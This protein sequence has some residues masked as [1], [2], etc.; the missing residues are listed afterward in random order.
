MLSDIVCFHVGHYGHCHYTLVIDSHTPA[1]CCR[2]LFFIDCLIDIFSHFLITIRHLPEYYWYW[3][4]FSSSFIFSVIV[5]SHYTATIAITPLIAISFLNAGHWCWCWLMSLWRP[6]I[7]PYAIAAALPLL[8]LRHDVIIS[9]R[10][11]LISHCMP[12]GW[13]PLILLHYFAISPLFRH[14]AAIDTIIF[15]LLRHIGHWCI[16]AISFIDTHW[17]IAFA[18]AAAIDT[19]FS[20]ISHCFPA[21][22]PLP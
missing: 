17:S 8:V 16:D 7:L 20:A 9:L 3:L 15:S 18:A 1:P 22:P 13:L 2:S 14:A 5:F 4:A 10:F 19:I 21:P 6:L 11:S 12:A